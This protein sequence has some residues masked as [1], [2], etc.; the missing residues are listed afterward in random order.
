MVGRKKVRD[1]ETVKTV[2]KSV[3]RHTYTALKRG[4]NESAFAFGETPGSREA[5]GRG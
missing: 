2:K 3:I 4:V 5:G 1:T